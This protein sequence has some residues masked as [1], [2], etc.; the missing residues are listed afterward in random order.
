MKATFENISVFIITYNEEE[1]LP[2]CIDS[3]KGSDDIVI[4]DSFSSDKTKEIALS[5]SVVR[6]FQ[7]PFKD[8]STQRND[9]LHNITFKNK[10]VFIIDADERCTPELW[11]EMLAK[12][13]SPEDSFV[14]Y[15][16][17]RKLYFQGKWMKHNT[18]S[19][20]WV[21]R[22]V[23]PQKVKFE[24][25]VHERLICDGKQ[26]L[27]NEQ[28]IHLS[29]SKGI[30]HWITR[31]NNYTTVIASENKANIN[32][33]DFFKILKGNPLERRRTV[34]MLFYKCRFRWFVFLL[35]NIFIKWS[36]L[37]GKKGLK[38]IALCSFT[39]FIASLKE[40]EISE[41]YVL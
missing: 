11:N 23:L 34:K 17:R 36:F 20:V 37:D 18:M 22:L 7:N 13:N 5:Y 40:K 10:W 30:S 31:M 6:F 25:E 28:L 15:S 1:N 26:G 41:K 16:L 21:E 38:Y 14:T 9:G 39:E 29:F 2:Y 24:R 27:L 8:F 12:I 19:P 32:K 33:I 35:I 3:V 4:F